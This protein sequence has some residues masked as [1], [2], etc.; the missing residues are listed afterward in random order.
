M[1]RLVTTGTV[2]ATD[3]AYAPA[4]G[5]PGYATD[6]YPGVRQQTRWPAYA[7]NM[8]CDSML[9]VLFAAGI[10]TDRNN[11]NLFSQSVQIISRGR[12]V[13]VDPNATSWTV[14]ANIY[15]IKVTVWGAGGGSGSS[16]SASAPGGGGGGGAV[17]A[18]RFDVT[19]NQVIPCR[20]GKGNVA[21]AGDSTSFA[22]DTLLAGGG[23]SGANGSNAGVGLGG[24]GGVPSGGIYQ[25]RGS[26]GSSGIIL[27]SSAVEGGRGGAAVMGGPPQ[28]AVGSTSV[29]FPANG[30]NFPGGGAT[31]CTGVSAPGADGQILIEY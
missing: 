15:R 12:E 9:H 21:A 16:S 31:G 28:F 5:T 2:S 8:I 13:V 22:S 30:G 24:G 4:T 20:T 23:A 14:P 3:A 1:D 25:R 7:W 29:P 18:M 11:W 6:G 19:P 10:G 27:S 26:A 17:A